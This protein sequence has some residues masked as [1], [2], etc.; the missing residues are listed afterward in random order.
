MTFTNV[1]LR[2]LFKSGLCCFAL[3]ISLCT[4][5]TTSDPGWSSWASFVS[6]LAGRDSQASDGAQL[7]IVLRERRANWTKSDEYGRFNFC[8]FAD[9]T[10]LAGTQYELSANRFYDLYGMFVDS[11]DLPVPDRQRQAELRSATQAYYENLAALSELERN[12]DQALKQSGVSPRN[13]SD[14][15]QW[16]KSS[17]F[18]DKINAQQLKV[19]DARKNVTALVDPGMVE[20]VFAVQ[21]ARDPQYIQ[22]VKSKDGAVYQCPQYSAAPPVE[23]IVAGGGKAS[24]NYGKES[25][26]TTKASAEIALSASGPFLKLK[27]AT[28]IASIDEQK[29]LNTLRVEFDGFGI[30]MIEPGMWFSQVLVNTYKDGPFKPG[31]AFNQKQLNALHPRATILAAGALFT[32]TLNTSAYR[33]VKRAYA[34]GSAISI[35]PYDFGQ[36]RDS[37]HPLN[38]VDFDDERNQITLKDRSADPM[39]LAI[40]SIP[41]K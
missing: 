1:P 40:M 36:R 34:A 10:T 16:Y 18:E 8:S 30:Q 31:S 28:G 26:T 9:S 20:T 4:A 32:L 27:T 24:W 23:S 21:R 38:E 2:F 41:L 13:P 6:R 15:Q 37:S 17:G 29:D 3:G 25:S 14:Y 7:Q 19:S 11:I 35:G 5:Q 33:S 39:V 12:K 22:A